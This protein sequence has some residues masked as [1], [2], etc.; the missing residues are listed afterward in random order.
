M[1][2]LGYPVRGAVVPGAALVR[3]RLGEIALALVAVFG[4]LVVGE[5]ALRLADRRPAVPLHEVCHCP[6]LY[7]LNPARPGISPQGLRDRVF[8]VPKPEG[9][10]RVLVLGDSVTFG[11]GVHAWQTFSKVLER[12]LQ[13]EGRH[14]EVL[15]SGVMG[16]TPYNELQWYLARGRTFAPDI[17]VVAFCMNDVVDPELHWS[18]TRREV[19]N[20]PAEAIPNLAY[21]ETHTARLL[22]PRLPWLG[23][24]SEILRRLALLFDPRRRPEWRERRYSNAGGRRIPTYVTE[25]D[26]LSIRV[27]TEERSPEWRWLRSVYSNLRRAVEA[28]GA[29]L[30]LLILPLAY[31]LDPEYPLLPQTA[32]QHY[33]AHEGIPCV[34]V[35]ESFRQHRADGLFPPR[36]GGWKDVWH[37]TPA[38]HRLVAAEL[39][40]AIEP[41]LTLSSQLARRDPA[42]H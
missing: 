32:F 29:R 31:Q 23:R 30:M 13:A 34:D 12:R 14:V 36:R 9:T 11:V 6:Y 24:R 22:G 20:V 10:T 26:D 21:H 38:G 19:I 42:F 40:S 8:A 2:D 39:T 17:V 35:L 28:D 37:L 5:L 16:Y 18:G 33:C 41:S 7:G 1:S 25:E 3:Q 4:S 27:L 15:N